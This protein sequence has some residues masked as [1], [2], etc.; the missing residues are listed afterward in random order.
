M[1]QRFGRRQVY[2]RVGADLRRPGI[3]IE[4]FV[5]RQML[6][7]WHGTCSDWR[8]KRQGLLHTDGGDEGKDKHHGTN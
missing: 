8:P 2:T 3:D 4:T 5:T 1:Y 6:A 7:V